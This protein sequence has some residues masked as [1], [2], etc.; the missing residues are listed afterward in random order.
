MLHGSPVLLSSLD[1]L[2]LESR[3]WQQVLEQEVQEDQ[4]IE[5]QVA[6][7]RL[8]QRFLSDSD[9]DL[10]NVKAFV[11]NKL[12]LHLLSSIWVVG[13]TLWE[14]VDSLAGAAL[15]EIASESFKNLVRLHPD[16]RLTVLKDL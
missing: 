9:H 2:V 4:C 7:M 13:L 8:L 1:L 3:Y 11:S 14:L 12:S 6:V 5:L 16:V 10:R 15:D